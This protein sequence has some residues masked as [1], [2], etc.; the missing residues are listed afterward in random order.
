MVKTSFRPSG[1]PFKGAKALA[2]PVVACTAVAACLSFGERRPFTLAPEAAPRAPREA[3]QSSG[4]AGS[5]ALAAFATAG[6][7]AGAS[8]AARPNRLNRLFS[9]CLPLTARAASTSSPVDMTSKDR[10]KQLI[11]ENGIMI[12]SKTTC[13]YCIKV[14]QVIGSLKRQPMAEPKPIRVMELDSMPASEAGA[15]QDVF[16]EMTGARTVPRVFVNGKCIGGCDDVVKLQEQGKLEEVLFA[17]VKE[18]EPEGFKMKLPDAE[19]K[20]KLDSKSYYILRQQGTE[21]PH[22]S[23][24]CTEMPKM[25]H[26]ACAACSLPL[27]SAKSKF[28]SSCGWPVFDKCYYSKQAGGCHV[29]VRKDY[30]GVEIV[31]KRCDSHLG[32]VFF[33]AFSASNPNGERH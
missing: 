28:K 15:M 27:Y 19:W 23:A 6:A 8:R 31:C 21:P 29:G 1:R 20:K 9:S 24:Y 18:A 5:A 11:G 7:A 14:K 13:P 3:P 30:G 22:S 32:H 25:G 4:A 2:G 17:G 12:F 16:E 33:D 10:V 26:F